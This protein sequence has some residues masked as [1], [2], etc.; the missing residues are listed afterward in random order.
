MNLR[1]KI[2]QFIYNKHGKPTHVLLRTEVYEKMINK[3][4]DYFD[5]KAIE[6]VKHEPDILWVGAEKKLKKRK[7]LSRNHTTK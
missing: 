2:P 4:E 3:L 6:E 5:Q 7:K 1:S